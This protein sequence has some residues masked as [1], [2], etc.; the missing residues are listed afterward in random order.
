LTSNS[1]QTTIGLLLDNDA[2]VASTAKQGW[3]VLHWVAAQ[4]QVQ[5]ARMVLEWNGNIEDKGESRRT[6][7]RVAVSNEQEPMVQLLPQRGATPHG[8]N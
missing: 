3:T 7:L 5:A 8:S 6:P 4:G 2:L 1:H